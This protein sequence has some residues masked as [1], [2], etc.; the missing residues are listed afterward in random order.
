MWMVEWK[1]W[2]EESKAYQWSS[3]TWD[4]WEEVERIVH[5]CVADVLCVDYRVTFFG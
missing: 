5:D 1:E 4:T 2:D 3:D